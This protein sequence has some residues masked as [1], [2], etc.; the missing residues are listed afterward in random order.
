MAI[1]Y[2][3]ANQIE[4]HFRSYMVLKIHFCY[5]PP[6]LCFLHSNNRKNYSCIYN[7][8]QFGLFLVHNNCSR[9]LH[10]L[11]YWM[12]LIVSFGFNFRRFSNSSSNILPKWS[13]KKKFPSF[14]IY[15]T[16][17]ALPEWYIQFLATLRRCGS[18]AKNHI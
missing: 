13:H 9:Y 5:S 12:W 6:P 8:V 3:E 16:P 7:T 15:H 1:R 11:H 4:N 18:S 14:H 17:F 2:S 10:W